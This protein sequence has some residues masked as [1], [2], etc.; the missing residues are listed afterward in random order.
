MLIEIQGRI[1]GVIFSHNTFDELR[2]DLGRQVVFGIA[3]HAKIH[4]LIS[5]ECRLGIVRDLSADFTDYA[6]FFDELGEG[7]MKSIVAFRQP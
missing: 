5:D 7:L 4:G 3:W 1:V 6:D 2:N